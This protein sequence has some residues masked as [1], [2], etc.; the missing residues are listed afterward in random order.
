MPFSRP[1]RSVTRV[2]TA[3]GTLL[4]AACTSVG[5]ET[6]PRDRF[7]YTAAISDSWKRQMLANIVKL[8]YGEP[9]TFMEVAS[10][11]NQYEL[12]GQINAGAGAGTGL[13]GGD[14]YTIGGA[15]AFIDRPTITYSPLTGAQFT[16]SLLTPI[17]PYALFGLVQSGY[18]A[19]TVF[20][21]VVK[22]INGVRAPAN[23]GSFAQPG[24]EDFNELLH[25]LR[26]LQM[27]GRVGMRLVPD[28][29]GGGTVLFFAPSASDEAQRDSLFV[30]ELLQLEPGANEFRLEFGAVARDGR[31]LAVLS[32]S[33]LEI[34][35]ELSA[36]VGVP[37]HHIAEGR[38]A[39]VGS[40]RDPML[41]IHS[42]EKQPDDAFVSMR[43]SD[44][45]YWVDD[46]DIRSKALLTF[47][48]ILFSLAET[49]ESADKPVITVGAGSG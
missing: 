13:T 10:V 39:P 48:M 17:S 28:E 35:I 43:Y 24:H 12:R 49:G 6:I 45:W 38:A 40:N 5:P 23:A 9:P 19:D 47:M 18:P 41:E 16:R 20:R 2:L 32:R 7:D 14:T 27:S 46:K 25:A 1:G 42:G 30:R 26:R 37:S 21:M 22:S 15:G 33:I 8:R 29:E 31:S 4:L 3:L 44:H 34:L 36:D 11:I